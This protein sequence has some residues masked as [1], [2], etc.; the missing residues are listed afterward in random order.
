MI[1]IV[2]GLGTSADQSLLDSMFEDRKRLFIDLLDWDLFVV[3]DRLEIDRFD[4][5]YATYI[6]AADSAGR[7]L[8]SLRLL[9]STRP[10]LLGPLFDRLCSN[11][12]P[13]EIGRALCRARVCQS[14]M[15]SGGAVPFNNNNY[16]KQ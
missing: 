13:V 14:V 2:E 15:I 8:A 16:N 5:A 11:G 6:I 9:P 4:D 1:H 10:P 7:H 12:V 3:D